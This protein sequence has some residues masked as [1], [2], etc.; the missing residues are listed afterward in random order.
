MNLTTL[1]V[2]GLQFET[3]YLELTE[4]YGVCARLCRRMWWCRTNRFPALLEPMVLCFVFCSWVSIFIICWN[5]FPTRAPVLLCSPSSFLRG[6]SSTPELQPGVSVPG[7]LQW[8]SPLAF[9]ENIIHFWDFLL[10]CSANPW[11]LQCCWPSTDLLSAGLRSPTG[12]LWMVFW[13]LWLQVSTPWPAMVWTKTVVWR[14][15]SSVVIFLRT[16][17]P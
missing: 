5:I 13:P 14:R 4:Q 8:M 1:L 3:G 7:T 15:Q 2:A 16:W 9:D 6:N 17:H 11:P 12:S 10:S